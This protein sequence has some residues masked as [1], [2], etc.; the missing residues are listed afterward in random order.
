MRLNISPARLSL[1]LALAAA[2]CAAPA[3]AQDGPGEGSTGSNNAGRNTGTTG[4]AG[5]NAPRTGAP[6][7]GAANGAPAE[8]RPW[9][10]TVG[11]ELKTTTHNA[12]RSGRTEAHSLMRYII[13]KPGATWTEAERATVDR[14]ESL[15][16]RERTK[17]F[18]EAYKGGHNAN[19]FTTDARRAP[20]LDGSV[21][22]YEHMNIPHIEVRSKPFENTREAIEQMRRLRADVKETIAFHTHYRFPYEASRIAPNAE[23]VTDYLRRV[24][25][26]IWLRR[27][28][29]SS[30]SDFV[31]KAMD[32]TPVNVSE[33]E[34]A[35]RTFSSTNT[36]PSND[37]IERRGIR[38]NRLNSNGGP[39][40]DIEF[41]G[42]MKDVS[43]IEKYIEMTDRAFRSGEFGPFR[44][45]EGSPLREHSS[46]DVL[47]FYTFGWH[48]TGTISEGE[49]KYIAEQVSRFQQQY[50]VRTSLSP[51]KLA[52]AI[53]TMA[54]ADTA[55]GKKMLMP[56]A[57]EW[58]FMPLESDRALPREVREQY[59]TKRAEY[60][61]KLVNLAERVNAGEF[62]RGESY[63][64]TKV[65]SRTRR[66]LHDFV[67]EGYTSGG[68]RGTL[69]DFYERSVFKPSSV[70]EANAEYERRT[71]RAGRE[72]FAGR[73]TG[74]NASGEM[75][76]RAELNRVFE[77]L[78]GNAIENAGLRAA[79]TEATSEA[80]RLAVE[81]LTNLTGTRLEVL[82]S[83]ELV[84]E[85][86]RGRNRVEISEGLLREINRRAET[87]PAAERAAF[88]N[89]TLGLMLGHELSHA[90]GIRSER[91]A[92]AEAINL[93]RRAPQLART[94]DGRLQP[95][96]EAD[97]RNAVRTFTEAGSAFQNTLYRIK[98]LA[99]YGTAGGREAAFVRVMNGQGDRFANYRRAD[100]TIRWNRVTADGV[101]R[102]GAGVSHFALALFL[103]ELAVVV[104]TGDRLR[105]E[106]FFDGVMTTDFFITY[107]LFS[108]GA[109]GANVAYSRYLAKYIKPKF[110]SGV[111]RTNIVLATGMALPEIALGHFNGRAFAINVAS[112]GLSTVAVKS[113]LQG[114]SWVINMR[115]AES[116]GRLA[117]A[118]VSL[119]RFAK[120]GGWFY[121]AAET[122]VVLYMGD[123]IAQAVTRYLDDRAARN[124][125]R[126]ATERLFDRTSAADISDEDF[127]A[128]LAAFN[129]VHID[130]RNFLYAPL[131]EDEA[132][133]NARLEGVSRDALRLAQRREEIVA[134]LDQLPA[135]KARAE[136][137]HGSVEGYLRSLEER[138]EAELNERVA[139]IM[140]TYNR[141]RQGHLEEVYTDH[142]R[143]D[144]YFD[145][146]A[147]VWV[148]GGARAGASGDPAS[149]RSDSHGRRIR[150]RVEGDVLDSAR[151][152]SRNRLQA[153]DDHIAVLEALRQA[154][155]GNATREAAIAEQIA[156][157]QE[158]KRRDGELMG[159]TTTD[160]DSD[161][162]AGTIEREMGGGR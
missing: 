8:A 41:R 124:A 48:G 22:W 151:D 128:E 39:S 146:D 44:Y 115:R 64:P 60:I 141:A 77:T 19:N 74:T 149:G 62:G 92:D 126:D 35:L 80:R 107:A 119:R 104:Q 127:A 28:V 135:L 83:S 25:W 42:L 29:V 78:R 161:G 11:F 112:L 85:Y 138:D 66:I 145:H 30:R 95:L 114:I 89:K 125:V 52:E 90:S 118:G 45:A 10:P 153:Y 17:F 113:G 61:R 23:A 98:N 117:R 154:H 33:L 108:A 97:V 103:K 71:G 88:R 84:V 136:R 93:V 143:D 94:A 20:F 51:E 68:R 105:I 159:V 21:S 47:K 63:K 3:L 156:Q 133:Y 69:A 160:V 58:I 79:S 87:V 26:S 37:I 54:T 53:R 1:P 101:L 121:T 5:P 155:A 4:E 6:A 32:N 140:E 46:R 75:M 122:A 12:D 72:G 139:E 157:M 38:V 49:L 65:A 102:Q 81:G 110:V 82:P 150:S 120:L 86:D 99:R 18:F 142:R 132:R 36:G 91:I 73:R 9:S 57:W 162:A 96:T 147:A 130:Y 70:A 55:A 158:I 106:E 50:N 15:N 27:A 123:E 137:E 40:L 59:E 152:V 7:N 34:K 116:V 109:Q 100:G 16:V 14:W 13:P 67:R 43:R 134:R 131:A 111:L 144:A 2:L 148:A 31:L 129:A 24:S 76:P 56:V